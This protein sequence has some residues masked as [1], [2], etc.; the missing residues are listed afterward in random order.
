MSPKRN[1]R[2]KSTTPQAGPEGGFL[3]AVL[4]GF[5]LEGC[6]TM[7]GPSA[8][9]SVGGD[10]AEA[11]S[12]PSN[13]ADTQG[14]T[15]TGRA[16]NGYLVNALVFQDANKDGLLSADE[17]L[18]LTDL[19]GNF[20]L[21]GT[22]SGDLIVKPINFLSD[23]EKLNSLPQLNSIG[24]Q[25]PDNLSTYYLN[26]DGT[27]TLFKGQLELASASIGTA[28]NIT[29]LTTMVNGLMSSGQF[30]L[31]NATQKVV[32]IFGLPP[33]TDYVAMA[34]SNLPSEGTAGVDLQKKAVALSNLLTSAL[35]FYE[36]SLSKQE[37]LE[38]LALKVLSK[39]EDVKANAVI[40][41]DI[42][43]YMASSADIKSILLEISSDN[44]FQVDLEKLNSFVERLVEI[45]ELLLDVNGISLI[46]D[47]GISGV[48]QITS[49]WRFSLPNQN[50][51]VSDYLFGVTHN[52]IVPV[53]D[54]LPNQWY[55]NPESLLLS[56]GLNTIY[57][58]PRTGLDEDTIRLS[59]N[60]DDIRPQLTTLDGVDPLGIFNSSYFDK[61]D[62]NYVNG[63]NLNSNF[64]INVDSN[65]I[66]ILPQYQINRA[67]EQKKFIAP[68]A[69][70]WLFFPNI[71]NSE[72]INGDN[73][74]LYYR[75]IDLAGNFSDY[76][77]FD[78]VYDNVAPANLVS[79]DISL[80]I[81]SGIYSNDNYS[82]SLRLDEF[83]TRFLNTY[84]EKSVIVLGQWA[85]E[86]SLINPEFYTINPAMPVVDGLYTL[87]T[88]QVDR[89]GNQSEVL[90]K[91][92][93]LDTVAP[94]VIEYKGLK[95][96]NQLTL[97]LLDYDKS[98]VSL[99][100]WLQYR[101]VN[102]ADSVA[103]KNSTEWVNVNTLDRSGK[104][105]M[106]FR[107]IDRAGNTSSEH[108][109]GQINVDIDAPILKMKDINAVSLNDSSSLLNWL[110]T[111]VSVQGEST[112]APQIAV[113]L[114]N[115]AGSVQLMDYFVTAKD[116]SGNVSAPFSVSSLKDGLAR[117]ELA[118]SNNVGYLL[119]AENNQ[120]TEFVSSA[121]EESL[122]AIGSI[123]SD[124]V[125]KLGVGDIFIGLGGG[126]LAVIDPSLTLTGLS[127]L[128]ESETQLFADS[129][130][131]SLTEESTQ[132]IFATPILKAYFESEDD[133]EAGGIGIFQSQF[134][135]YNS[136]TSTEFLT[137]K[138]NPYL[139]KWFV[140]L[141]ANDDAVYF[142]GDAMNVLG[143]AGSDLL[144]G[145]AG[146]DYIVAGSN[147]E[148][149]MDIVRGYAG[150]DVLVGGDAYFHSNVNY[151]LEGGGGR[152]TLI[153]GNGKG[154]LEGGAGN[155]L[156]VLAPIHDSATPFQIEISD[157]TPGT[158]YLQIL[159]LT[160]DD[161]MKGIFVN[162]SEGNVVIDLTTLLGSE[163]APFGSTLTFLGVLTESLL[164]E[165]IVEGWFDFSGSETF[166]WTDLGIDT[167]SWT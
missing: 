39:L 28:V 19:N 69:N 26:S 151:L 100:E 144:Q 36:T 117:I 51:N 143:G 38:L 99:N 159:G 91:N 164:P 78:F 132:R 85:N 7:Y 41:V 8:G 154:T 141:G 97:P 158:D 74:R 29:P 62:V 61:N 10:G 48:D 1:V 92:F 118:A 139:N 27:K 17:N 111:S 40:D 110:K 14:T 32:N 15:I 9:V 25:N 102:T 155:D 123:F 96:T 129:F 106:Y 46:N 87:A 125:S 11:S 90:Y 150:D 105:D 115:S 64:F 75:Q 45:N 113:H 119:K 163:K 107:T 84:D 153:A 6:T 60:Y 37:V 65:D 152:D 20:K 30:D 116:N 81:D 124:K 42:S 93:I 122:I 13:S 165:E 34:S 135:Q 66:N 112:I 134:A 138:W 71:S 157:F 82:N 130:S 52:L 120:S 142:G 73:F 22:S 24:I 77:S 160:S 55:S 166:Q 126:D 127:F 95:E 140:D 114:E 103:Q 3:L 16:I 56:Q 12:D 31:V 161:E 136:A 5:L 148:A 67:N 43:R 44:N 128:N 70:E 156:F 94:E 4:A 76:S 80:R 133:P 49:D 47:T 88:L 108:Y 35:E 21:P 72:H 79:E 89:S 68:N 57:V 104:Y 146:D 58:K 101:M 83:R 121:G 86:Q 149:G 147:S 162:Q 131:A 53:D 98:Q 109:A 145:G 54:L 33:S 167:I 18:A 2:K 137:T 50:A 23:A 63:V 59:I